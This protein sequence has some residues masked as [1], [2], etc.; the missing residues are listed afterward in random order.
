VA[1][2]FIDGGNQSIQR[3]LPTCH[4]LLAHFIT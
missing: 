1:V 3:K 4:K 2:S